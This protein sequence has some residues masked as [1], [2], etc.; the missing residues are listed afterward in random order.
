[1]LQLNLGCSIFVAQPLNKFLSTGDPF[2]GSNALSLAPNFVLGLG[3]GP[4]A[5]KTQRILVVVRKIVG[6]E[7]GSAYRSHQVVGVHAGEHIC[8]DDVVA[9]SLDQRLLVFIACVGLVG[10]DE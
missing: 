4:A 5:G 1:M 3:L 9:C 2:D 10:R 8:L 7:P 6:A